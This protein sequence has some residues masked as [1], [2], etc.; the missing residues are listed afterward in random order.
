[1]A[2]YIYD[3]SQITTASDLDVAD[4]F[5]DWYSKCLP[6][7]VF[8]I[9]GNDSA[10]ISQ[11]LR[12]VQSVSKDL[13]WVEFTDGDT[14]ILNAEA[15]NLITESGL[16]LTSD[17]AYCLRFYQ[18][19]V[20]LPSSQGILFEDGVLTGG[21]FACEECRQLEAETPTQDSCDLC[22]QSGPVWL[23]VYDE[24]AREELIELFAERDLEVPDWLPLNVD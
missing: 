24:S 7:R 17:D 18:T 1:M 10:E 13:I 8:E 20:A 23:T 6:T 12:E 2:L 19:S 5:C 15:A 3:I 9:K 11:V 22:D 16:N 14:R 21:N 4:D